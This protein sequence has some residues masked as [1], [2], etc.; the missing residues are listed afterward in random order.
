MLRQKKNKIRKWFI[1]AILLIVLTFV[2]QKLYNRY[3]YTHS[4]ANLTAVERTWLN[5][6]EDVKEV[7]TE[8]NLPTNYLLA[9]IALE[10]TGRKEVPS[11]YESHIFN[12]LIKVRDGDIESFEGIVQGDIINSNDDALKNLASS[13][14]AFST[15]GLSVF[16]SGYKDKGTSGQQIS[17]SWGKMDKKCLWQLF[18]EKKI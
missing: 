16:A 8:L 10:C 1:A 7:S 18:G 4:D 9:L 3:I 11:R 14:G 15:H 6:S 13:W 5:Y 2:V 17:I 12:K